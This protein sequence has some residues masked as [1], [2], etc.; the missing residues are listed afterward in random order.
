MRAQQSLK[1]DQG[2]RATTVGRL[3]VRAK[4]KTRLRGNNDGRDV[5]NVVDDVE[6]KEN[7][8]VGRWAK[9]A[10]VEVG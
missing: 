2:C 10:G 4:E 6:R 5:A 7:D 9:I 1:K 8:V 3:L